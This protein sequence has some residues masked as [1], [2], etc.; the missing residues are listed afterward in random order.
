M[1]VHFIHVFSDYLSRSDIISHG[2]HM[3][4]LLTQ[5]VVVGFREP[6]RQV[7]P[8]LGLLTLYHGFRYL[9]GLQKDR[10]VKDLIILHE[11]WEE[12]LCFL[13]KDWHLH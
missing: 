12:V 2:I 10:L 13:D 9:D 8:K 7:V 3:L 1:R 6:L 5:A 4:K 11:V